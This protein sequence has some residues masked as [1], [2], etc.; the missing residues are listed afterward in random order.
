MRLPN[1]LAILLSVNVAADFDDGRAA[2]NRG[3]YE[4][5]LFEWQLSAEQGNANAQFHLGVM[6]RH[7]EGVIQDYKEAVKWYIKAAEQG[8]ATAQYNLGFM[9]K[10]GKALLP[11]DDKEAVKWY[12]KAAEGGD[13]LAQVNLGVMYAKGR[14]VLKNNVYAHM[15][16]NIASS[17]GSEDAREN[18]DLVTKRMTPDQLAEAQSLARECVKKDYKNC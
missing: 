14:G 7:G 11:Q 8:N 5:A 3:D 12:T 18:R 4:T 10:N 13:A 1:A 16:F 15:W 2:Y 6:Y 17:N 9:Y